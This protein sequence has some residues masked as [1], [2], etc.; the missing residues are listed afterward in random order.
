MTPEDVSDTTERRSRASRTRTSRDGLGWRVFGIC[1][2]LVLLA[3]FVMLGFI[4]YETWGRLGEL[5]DV[6]SQLEQERETLWAN[7]SS[8]GVPP[9]G[10]QRRDDGRPLAVLAIPKLGLRWTI[11]EGTAPKDL[12]MAPGHYIGTAAAGQ[13]GNFAV[14]GHRMRGMFWDLDTVKA[15]DRITVEDR[16][17]RYVY[18]VNTNRIVRPDDAGVILPVPG[19]PGQTPTVAQLTLTT[20]NPKWDNYQRLIVGAHLVASEPK[21]PNEGVR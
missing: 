19:Q 3:G 21:P 12:R 16:T 13:I 20:C 2:E 14:A 8:G 1:G 15:G 7:E 17:S 4:A 10:E 9:A 5:S 6:Q 18:E 11:V